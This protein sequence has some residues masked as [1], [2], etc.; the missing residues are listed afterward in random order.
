M[1][2]LDLNAPWDG[3]KGHAC[4]HTAELLKER[5]TCDLEHLQE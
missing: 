3:I 1:I 2:H 4:P 5:S